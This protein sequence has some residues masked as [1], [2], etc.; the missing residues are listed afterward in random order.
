LTQSA[1]LRKATPIFVVE[2]IEPVLPFWTLLGFS[3]V[4]RVPDASAGDGRLAFVILAADGIEIMYQTMSSIAGDL[5]AAAVKE[6]FRTTPQQGI[7][8]F[9]VTDILDIE[10]KLGRERQVMPRR[11]TFYGTTEVGYTDPAGNIIVFAQHRA[12]LPTVVA[13]N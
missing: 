12:D 8:F 13:R 10:T 3:A 7:L 5:Q 4:T 6:A 11:T 1:V 2:R 9:E